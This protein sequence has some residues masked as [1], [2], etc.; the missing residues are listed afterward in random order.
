M[1]V[2]TSPVSLIAQRSKI[3]QIEPRTMWR[4]KL[5]SSLDFGLGP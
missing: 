4:F 2:L 1:T 3:I 5:R